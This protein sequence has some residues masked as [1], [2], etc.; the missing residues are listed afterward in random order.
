MSIEDI[1][2]RWDYTR[3]LV[4]LIDSGLVRLF[5]DTNRRYRILENGGQVRDLGTFDKRGYRRLLAG[6]VA[7][8]Y[9]S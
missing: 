7:L 9:T 2:S 6:Y 8:S 5:E 4:E 3:W 1:R